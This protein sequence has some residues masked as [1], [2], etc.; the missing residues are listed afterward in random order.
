[1][2][3]AESPGLDPDVPAS[4][5]VCDY[6]SG[7][8]DWYGPDW[9]LGDR[10]S[11]L[12]PEAREMAA[13]NGEF[14]DLGSGF[15]AAGSVLDVAQ[16][17]DLHAR[18]ACVDWDE[19]VAGELGYGPLLEE[20]GVKNAA[21]VLA[22]VRDPGKVLADPG[23]AGL[24]DPREPCCVVLGAVLHYLPARR[25]REVAAGYARLVAPGSLIVITMP[26]FDDAEVF[27]QVRQAY[28]PA[29]L[30]N[31]APGAVASFFGGLALTPPGLVPAQNWRGGWHDVPTTKPGPASVLAGVAR[32]P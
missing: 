11:E 25:A 29:R 9:E 16:A 21:M 6:L 32:K 1:M 15:P 7:G 22:D 5:R 28:T 4:S 20:Q 14:I 26:R 2:P 30:Y 24:I 13:A 23:L 3:A 10:I 12:C 19:L 8:Y 27:R 17:H 18:V 31:H